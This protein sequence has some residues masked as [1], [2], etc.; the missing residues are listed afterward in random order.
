MKVNNTTTPVWDRRRPKTLFSG[1][2]TCGSCGGNFAKVTKTNFGCTSARNK[3]KA[4]CT[5]MAAISQTELE[6]LVLVA[7]QNNLMDQDALAVFC[8]AY[9]KERNH[10]QATASKNRNALEN[11]LRAVKR[12]HA[13]LVDAIIAG[14]PADQ[15]K[16]RM[17]ALDARRIFDHF[18]RR[19]QF[20]NAQ[21]FF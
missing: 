3:G 12:D 9:A 11:E 15:V 8:E 16:D 2:M 14:I 13:K 20:R 21:N 19:L 5:N 4:F 18:Q 17:L 10:L 1:L 6:T 7:M